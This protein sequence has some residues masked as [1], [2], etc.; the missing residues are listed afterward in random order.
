MLLVDP[1]FTLNFP[2]LKGVCVGLPDREF[3][4]SLPNGAVRSMTSARSGCLRSPCSELLLVRDCT[5][6]RG[7]WQ[8]WTAHRMAQ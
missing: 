1:P 8:G 5:D 3:A 2:V 4:L 6:V 7:C